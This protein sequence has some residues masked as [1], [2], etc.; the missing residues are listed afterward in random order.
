MIDPK[1]LHN[2][3]L[4]SD[5][6]DALDG[7]DELYDDQVGIDA[8]AADMATR[9]LAEMP[10][11]VPGQRPEVQRP[12]YRQMCGVCSG[13]G[14]WHRK[15]GHKCFPCKG[16]GYIE[17]STSP[18]KRARD[19][20]RVAQ[21][22]EQKA[23]NHLEQF[24]AEH[25]EFKAWWTD[26]TFGF[27]ISLRESVQRF[28]SL[29]EKQFAAAKKCIDGLNQRKAEAQQ[30]VDT[31]KAVSI[32]AI[33]ECFARAG[34][35]LQRPRLNLAGFVFSYAPQTSAN[36][37]ALYVKRKNDGTYLGKIKDGKLF[38]SRDCDTEA[39]SEIIKVASAPQDAAIAYGRMTGTCAIC[40]R[41]LDNKDSIARGI[42][43]ICAEKFGW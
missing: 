40:S 23:T 42:G 39:E 21:K 29:T 41:T 5:F 8:Y 22:K 4:P 28:G 11:D 43:P 33:E 6:P 24:E 15:P 10:D 19:R 20:A 14:N 30:R 18:E 34:T 17:F 31:A 13:T 35:L 25:P 16:A 9:N 26:T 3:D 2:T 1:E 36:A 32:E 37:G 7:R 27:A 38:R 12:T